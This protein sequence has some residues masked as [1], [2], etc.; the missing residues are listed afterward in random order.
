MSPILSALLLAAAGST[1]AADAVSSTADAVPSTTTSAA[2]ARSAPAPARGIR[3]FGIG[4]DAGAPNGLALSLVYR[5]WHFLRLHGGVAHNA[6]SVGAHGGVSLIP[7]KFFVTPALTFEGGEFFRGGSL[8]DSLGIDPK[9]SDV[10]KRVTY[11]Y[12]S[13]HLGLEFGSL[14]TFTFFIHGGLSRVWGTVD[15]L[16]GLLAN[17][18][19]VEGVTASN[20]T[21][22]MTIPSAKIG[23][24]LY[25]L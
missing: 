2:D 10:A 1:G 5:P 23:F 18:F 21:I 13:L 11:G 6:A 19:A 4:L 17:T 7:F 3:H 24:Y 9:A 15:D 16:S 8:V 20:A 12:A 25:F 22:A 14:R